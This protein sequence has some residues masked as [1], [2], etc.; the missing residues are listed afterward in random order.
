M[1]SKE[2]NKLNFQQLTLISLIVMGLFCLAFPIPEYQAKALI[3]IMTESAN[4]NILLMVTSSD[5]IPYEVHYSNNALKIV[6]PLSQANQ[7]QLDSIT[8]DLHPALLSTENKRVH[9]LTLSLEQYPFV[10]MKPVVSPTRLEWVFS[11]TYPFPLAGKTIVLDPGHGAYDEETLS[12]YDTGVMKFGLIESQLNLQIAQ[13]TRQ[14]LEEW[15][16]SVILTRELEENTGTILFKPRIDFVNTL[17]PDLYLAIHHNDSDFNE[18]NGI[19]VYYNQLRSELFANYLFTDVSDSVGLKKNHI[20]T[21]PL[22]TLS[23]LRIQVAAL[24]ECSFVS[25]EIDRKLLQRPD[26]VDKVSFGIREAIFHYFTHAAE[27]K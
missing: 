1:R 19:F 23:S 26:Y 5:V 14:L 20:L 22:V 4:E 24:I 8:K 16:A 13:H 18:P 11:R 25:S 12:V 3:T 2:G 10:Q 7:F 15:G 6:F 27:I 9:F 21:D 17:Q